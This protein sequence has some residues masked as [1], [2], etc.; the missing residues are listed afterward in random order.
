MQAMFAGIA[1]VAIASKLAPSFPEVVKRVRLAYTITKEEMDEGL[2][3]E[4]ASHRAD[5]LAY[6]MMQTKEQVIS[7]VMA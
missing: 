5:A 6:S 4:I 3:G 2:Y 7:R 1:T